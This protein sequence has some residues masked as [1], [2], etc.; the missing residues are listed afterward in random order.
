[1]N[2]KGLVY[3]ELGEGLTE[4]E[5]AKLIEVPSR[6]IGNILSDRLPKDPTIWK[7][8]ARYFRMDIDLL[9]GDRSLSATE[10]HGNGVAVPMRHVP[11][12]TWAQAGH[13]M[14]CS[15]LSLMPEP[16]ALLETDVPG[17]KTFALRVKDDSMNPM[18]GEG[19]IVFI[20]PAEKA[21]HG[22]YVFAAFAESPASGMLRQLH[23]VGE[24]FVLH[25]LNRRY[26]DVP[27]TNDICIWGKVVRL[28]KNL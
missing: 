23:L 28:R 25:P 5:L 3:R 4:K 11:L 13:M 17:T 26:H 20:N 9:R 15:H 8:F 1:M 27:L 22:Q 16:E 14:G 12:F 24:H 7:K 18:F 6:E 21:V 10:P 19:E 2:L